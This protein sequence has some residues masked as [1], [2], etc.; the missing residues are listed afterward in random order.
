MR[1]YGRASVTLT[2]GIERDDKR[3][4]CET[5]QQQN[6]ATMGSRRICGVRPETLAAVGLCILTM[7]NFAAAQVNVNFD[8]EMVAEES[9]RVSQQSGAGGW[10]PW[11]RAT[12]A[13]RRRPT[14]R[15]ERRPQLSRPWPDA[16]LPPAPLDG[17]ESDWLSPT[18]REPWR[19]KYDRYP[20]EEHNAVFGR[21][22]VPTFPASHGLGSR[23]CAD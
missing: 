7:A 14:N 5:G 12:P 17:D 19:T 1:W 11:R 15:L 8:G 4:F 16:W 3:R 22:A 18:L 9:S 20:T 23:R 6:C 10:E 2:T 21:P 13:D